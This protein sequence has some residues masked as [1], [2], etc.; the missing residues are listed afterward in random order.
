MP[1][2]SFPVGLKNHPNMRRQGLIGD[3]NWVSPNFVLQF[4]G[5]PVGQ[6]LIVSCKKF[7]P[8]YAGQYRST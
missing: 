1:S 6:D 2:R 7:G 3:D 4:A 8:Q 5:I